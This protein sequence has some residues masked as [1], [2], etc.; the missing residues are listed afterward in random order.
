MDLTTKPVARKSGLVIQEVPDELLVYDLET[1]KAHCLNRSAAVVWRLCD[2][3]NAAADIADKFGSLG[4]SVTE[5]FVWLALDQLST[6]KLLDVEIMTP[7]RTQSRRKVLKTVGLASMA[8]LP[9]IAS[10]AA[11]KSALAFT[12]CACANPQQCLG[13]NGTNNCNIQGI[14][15]P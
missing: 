14:C 9:I 13:C 11:P 3:Q 12:S 8:A 4:S 10:L 2:G 1:N 15:A 6:N 5:D 7:F